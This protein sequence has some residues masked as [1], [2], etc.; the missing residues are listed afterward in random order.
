MILDT[1]ALIDLLKGRELPADWIVKFD[2]GSEIP[3][4]TTISAMELWEGA[5]LSEIPEE[6]VQKLEQV[7]EGLTV[8]DFTF[9]DGKLSGEI[10]ASLAKAGKSI[11][12]EDVMIASIALNAR[13]TVLTRNSDHFGRI[14]GLRM[15]S[16]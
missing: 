7:L 4:I 11:D 6:E 2:S 3:V 13:E 1:S 15:E 8:R 16:Y 10:K 14:D 12:T 5:H 9:E